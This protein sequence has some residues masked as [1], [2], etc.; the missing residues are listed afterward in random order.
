MIKKE[1]IKKW[2]R[3]TELPFTPKGN[4]I[5][6]PNSLTDM[7]HDCITELSQEKQEL[8]EKDI[9]CCPQCGSGDVSYC[10]ISVRPHCNECK[11]WGMINFTGTKHDSIKRWNDEATRAGR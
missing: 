5:V 6:N 11:Y 2:V 3:D 1:D 7:I 4:M 10:S 8:T 9:M